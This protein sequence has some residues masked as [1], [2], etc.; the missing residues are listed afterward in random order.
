M[1]FEWTAL[2]QRINTGVFS[3]DALR[4]ALPPDV[5]A[6]G[7]LGLPGATEQQ[8]IDLETHVGRPLPP[9]YREFLQTTNGWRGLNMAIDIVRSTDTVD[10]FRT[11]NQDWIDAFFTGFVGAPDSAPEHTLPRTLQVS[12]V[13][14]SAVLLLNPERPT[15]DGE[16]EAWFF[17]DWA[18]GAEP[19]PN[20]YALME[21]QCQALLATT[22]Q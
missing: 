10:W 12:D 3:S 22:R 11:E 1:A 16:C 2:L 14:D 8:L 9:S 21:A 18:P 17:A 19:Y 5:V 6:S 13:G 15:A 7:W 4:E 20:F